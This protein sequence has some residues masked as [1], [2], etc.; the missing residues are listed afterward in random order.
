MPSR[1]KTDV[2]TLIAGVTRELR[3]TQIDF[4]LIGG[5]AVLLHGRPRATEDIDL[6]L[7][8]D[9]SRL[10]DVLMVCKA[11]ELEVLADDVE[12]FVRQSFVL[13]AADEQTGI[14]V[15]FIFSSTGYERTAIA[16]ADIV[17][18]ESESVPFAAVED[19][20][21]LKLIAGRGVDIEDVKTIVRRKEAEI[22]W[23]Y[24]TDWIRRF[25]QIEGHEDLEDRLDEV[26]NG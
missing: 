4:M 7:A 1:K 24:V 19:L 13:P 26:R 14:R 21:I 20:I 5:Q 12:T 23:V 3:A 11:L 15:D 2:S 6:T 18:V 22:D 10:D 9:P 25:R 17:E 8:A 16:R